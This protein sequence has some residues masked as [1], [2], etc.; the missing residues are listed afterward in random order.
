VHEKD[1][2]VG[3]EFE[4]KFEGASFGVLK[5][6]GEGGLAD[7]ALVCPD[8]SFAFLLEQVEPVKRIMIHFL[9]QAALFNDVTD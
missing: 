9:L 7:P 1:Q 8:K 3:T 5:Q 6:D 4:L 2:D